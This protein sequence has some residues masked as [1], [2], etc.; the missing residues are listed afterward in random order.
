MSKWTDYSEKRPEI[1]GPYEWSI[2]SKTMKA[3]SIVIV[4]WMRKRGAGY[5]DVL[6]P[7]FDYWDGYRVHVPA[8]TKWRE[9]RKEYDN[10][11]WH[12]EIVIGL[13]GHD[14]KRCE[15]CGSVPKIKAYEKTG[16][17][18]CLNPS[19][20]MLNCF[21]LECCE[22]GNV[23]SAKSIIEAEN[24][25]AQNFLKSEAPAL[26]EAL[27][28]A[29]RFIDSHVADPDITPEMCKAYEKYCSVDAPALIA[30]HRGES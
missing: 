30:K 2:P 19:P 9:C 6:S 13:E 10:I 18:I 26:L 29:V 8:G 28:A 3:E 20:D 5:E 15:F 23:Q 25:R 27:T 4:A 7:V 1:A 21:C 17:G 16:G 22:Y 12:E 14:I 11:E 24:K